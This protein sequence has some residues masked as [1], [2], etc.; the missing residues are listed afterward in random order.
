MSGNRAIVGTATNAAYIFDVPVLDPAPES[1][2]IDEHFELG[3]GANWTPIAGSSFSVVSNGF[4]NV[5]RQSSVT[6]NAGSLLTNSMRK[7]QGVQADITP[8][9]FDGSDRWFGLVSRYDL[10]LELVHNTLRGYVNGKLLVER[11]VA[12]NGNGR[13]GLAMHKTRAVFDDFRA[14]LH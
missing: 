10:R 8:T 2:F 3:A 11:P 5:Y 4:S 9:A 1:F 7:D 13:Y 12:I 6:G 14:V